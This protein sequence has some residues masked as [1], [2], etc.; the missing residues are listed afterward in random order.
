MVNIIE[1]L[2][3]E[4]RDNSSWLLVYN[5]NK[6]TVIYILYTAHNR[7]SNRGHYH[8]HVLNHVERSQKTTGKESKLI[9]IVFMSSTILFVQWQI[10]REPVKSGS[11]ELVLWYGV[12]LAGYLAQQCVID[13]EILMG[14]KH[15]SCFLLFPID[16]LFHPSIRRASITWTDRLW[17]ILSEPLGLVIENWEEKNTLNFKRMAS[18]RNNFM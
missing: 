17:E 18:E 12:G 1:I 9:T 16:L 4:A 5:P 8:L 2:H 15:Y 6:R 11:A 3:S 10:R 14:E 7:P 13:G